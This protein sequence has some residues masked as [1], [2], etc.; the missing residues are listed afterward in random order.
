MGEALMRGMVLRNS[1]PFLLSFRELAERTM[2]E[3]TQPWSRG[4]ELMHYGLWGG[5]RHEG[6]WL[7]FCAFR[8]G[9][10]LV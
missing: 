7:M 8:E 3:E 9:F 5:G 10:Q 6:V 4:H 1:V 2:C